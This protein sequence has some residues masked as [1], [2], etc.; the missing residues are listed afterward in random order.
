MR[1]GTVVHLFIR[2][3]AMAAVLAVTTPTPRAARAEP[4]PS[5]LAWTQV[6]V[7]RIL[8]AFHTK[9]PSARAL[10][11]YLTTHEARFHVLSSGQTS[12]LD[13]YD[14]E[15]GALV[16]PIAERWTD[17]WR[18]SAQRGH[19]LDWEQVVKAGKAIPQLVQ[20]ALAR[21]GLPGGLVDVVVV[22]WD[23]RDEEPHIRLFV[24]GTRKD[25][26]VRADLSGNVQSVELSD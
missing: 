21:V 2:G 26:V 15:K 8:Q 6:R 12:S 7:A 24:K 1:R 23:P 20:R 22:H 4:A 14:Y 16:G 17:K 5:S 11:V 19:V 13:E 10:G 18:E 9:L 25:G 3:V